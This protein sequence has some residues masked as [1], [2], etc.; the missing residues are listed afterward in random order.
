MFSTILFPIRKMNI[1]IVQKTLAALFAILCVCTQAVF[2]E[3]L[4][5]ATHTQEMIFPFVDEHVHASSIVQTPGGGF[6]CVWFQGSGERTAN[7]VRLMG[8][9][10]KKG[11][12][13]WSEPFPMADTPGIPDCNPIMFINRQGKLYLV[14][15]AVLADRWESSVLRVRSSVDYENDGPPNWNWQDNILFKPTD[16]FAVEYKSKIDHADRFF[17]EQAKEKYAALKEKTIAMSENLADRSLGWM[18]RIQPITLENGRILLP[19]YSDGYHCGLVAYSDDHGETWL[20]GLPIVGFGIQPA[21]AVRRNGDI[22]AFM[23]NAAGDGDRMW[24]SVSR[25]NG[26]SWEPA[27]KTERKAIA[28]VELMK[29]LDGRWLSIAGDTDTGRYRLSL[30]L[31]QDEGETWK[32]LGAL[33]YDPE[34]KDRFSYPCLIQSRDGMV[35]VT[36][37][38]HL[39]K[40][41]SVD[42]KRCRTIMH[43][44]LDP[45]KFDALLNR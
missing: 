42:G 23:R 8:A 19:L 13:K 14:W 11:Q 16:D 30:Y 35:H 4:D 17:S 1:K 21:L 34:G 32:R 43:T 44:C 39:E 38:Y 27:V 31:S 25:D 26:Y 40:Q 18:P 15:I 22:V 29:L 41:R 2:A 37:S 5:P 45:K 7:D 3:N 33:A 9:R 6:L 12:P 28:S 20:P 10:L 24:T 36:F